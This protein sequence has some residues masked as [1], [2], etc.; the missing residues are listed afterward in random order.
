MKYYVIR[1]TKDG[2]EYKQFKCIDGWTKDKS[3]CW[4]FSKQGA[5]KIADRLNALYEIP[6]NVHYNILPAEED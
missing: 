6:G 1:T 3:L 4:G 5:Q 2:I